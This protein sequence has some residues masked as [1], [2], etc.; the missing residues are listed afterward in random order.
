MKLVVLT[1]DGVRTKAE[2]L[3]GTY[4][5]PRE[6]LELDRA[7]LL[8]LRDAAAPLREVGRRPAADRAAPRPSG[9]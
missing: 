7:E 6:L 3:A 5:P 8:A 9:T 2:M 4:E 1:A